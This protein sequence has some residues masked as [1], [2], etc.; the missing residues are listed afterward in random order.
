MIGS[1]RTRTRLDDNKA[2]ADALWKETISGD[3]FP[4]SRGSS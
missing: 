3:P 1:R 4:L 2:A